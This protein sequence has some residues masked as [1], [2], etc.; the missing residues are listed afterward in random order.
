VPEVASGVGM[1]MSASAYAGASRR[2]ECTRCPASARSVVE[3]LLHTVRRME[4]ARITQAGMLFFDVPGVV[5]TAVATVGSVLRVEARA[6]AATAHCPDCGYRSARVHG[7]YSRFPADLPTGSRSVVIALR[8]RRFVCAESGCPRRTFV[9]QIDGLT[10]RHGRWTERLRTALGIIGLAL[11]GRAGARMAARLGITVSRS[12]LI[13]LVMRLP[14]PPAGTPKVLGVDEFALRRG[15]VYGTL[16][17]DGETHR[18]IDVLPDREADTL[19]A[20]LAE[21]DGVEVI[22]RDRAVFYAEGASRSAPKAVQ[23]ADRWHLWHN[24]GEAT[25]RCVTRHR[26]CLRPVDGGLADERA[27]EI[28]EVVEDERSSTPWRTRHRFAERTRQKHAR[29]HELLNQGY[30][31]R[32]AARALG[33][34]PRT[35]A[36]FQKAARPEDLFRGQWQDRASKLDPFKLFLQQQWNEGC[37]NAWKLYEDI[38]A[39]GYQGSYGTF[40][41]YLKP[42][43]KVPGPT[44]PR[45][46]SAVRCPLSAVRCPLSAVRCPLS[47]RSVAGWILSRPGTLNELQHRQLKTIL[48]GCPELAALTSHVRAFATMLTQRRGERLPAW[49]AA[50]HDDDLPSLHRF[51]SHLERDLDAV[52]AGLTLPWNSGVV[53]GHVN[54]SGGP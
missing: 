10:R 31:Q 26:T 6:T 54:P 37:T 35:V 29:I 33:M 21:R 2:G 20:W 48:D 12:S 19:A 4:N 11:A 40:K 1:L 3:V 39:T 8:V 30:S 5:S 47:A 44:G 27:P 43:R 18:P 34:T 49:I 7:S 42:F 45:P 38:K 46:L 15:R 22:C 36:R 41:D 50:V 16:L 51:A 13:R 9:E 32:G 17:V 28:S 25:E 24:L 23:C 52:I 14:V 53:E